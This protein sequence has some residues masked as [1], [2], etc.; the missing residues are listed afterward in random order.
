M[1][2]KPVLLYLHNGWSSFVRKDLR[3][4]SD[5]F[6]IRVIPFIP[7][8]K[9]MVPFILM[10]H[11]F[12][13]FINLFSV[14]LIVCQFA[15]YHTFL[16][17]ILGKLFGKKVFIVSGGTDCVSFPSINYG[18]LRKGLMRWF[19]SFSYKNC[20]KI[21]PV[22]ESLLKVD[23]SYTHTDFTGQGILFHLPELKT[24]YQVI[25][26]GYDPARWPLGPSVREISFLTV[27]A[28]L[29]MGFSKQLKGIDLFLAAAKQFP[30][31]PFTIVGAKPEEFSELPGNVSLIPIVPNE[32]LPAWYAKH[33]FYVQLSMSEGFPNA[34]SE[35]MLCG[36]IPIVS[37]VGAM[38]DI[39]GNSGYILMNRDLGKLVSLIDSAI[40]KND[41]EALSVL[42]RKQIAENYPES[43]RKE[44]LIKALSN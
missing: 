1:A 41:F 33:R 44:K 14:R 39:V 25:Y 19:I 9:W 5:D 2:H 32:D 27:A 15:G 34:L 17:V 40:K 43:L 4:L 22:H 37:S 31:Y 10:G 23:Y 30:Q 18:G 7:G 8:Q 3:L 38:P 29:Q 12:K 42:A 16:P 21:L 26:N 6:E 11:F 28:G 13:I 20:F 35:A 24:P 36:C